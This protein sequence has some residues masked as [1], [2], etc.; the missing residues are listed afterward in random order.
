MSSVV[1]VASHSALPQKTPFPIAGQFDIISLKGWLVVER[2][3]VST[4]G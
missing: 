2:E 3:G 1:H 4:I